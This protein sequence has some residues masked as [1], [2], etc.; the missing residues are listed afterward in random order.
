MDR[1]WETIEDMFQAEAIEGGLEAEGEQ[2]GLPASLPDFLPEQSPR[3]EEALTLLADPTSS[4]IPEDGESIPIVAEGEEEDQLSVNL[5]DLPEELFVGAPVDVE[6]VEVD[7][8][9]FFSMSGS[10]ANDEFGIIAVDSSLDP[11]GSDL[12]APSSGGGY[13]APSYEAYPLEDDSE[14][15]E[16]APSTYDPFGFDGGSVSVDYFGFE[17]SPATTSEGGMDSEGWDNIN[18]S[19]GAYEPWDAQNPENPSETMQE[20]VPSTYDPFG[21]DGG[22]VSVDYFGF[23]A[24]PGED[25]FPNDHQD[26]EDPSAGVSYAPW[27]NQVSEDPSKDPFGGESTMWDN[28]GDDF[29]WNS[30]GGEGQD[31][32]SSLGH[33]DEFAVPQ[34]ESFDNSSPFPASQEP[35][36]IDR[37]PVEE[38]TELPSDLFGSGP[39]EFDGFSSYQEEAPVSLPS[40]GGFDDFGFSQES[41]AADFDLGLGG[42]GNVGFHFEPQPSIVPSQ[43]LATQ[44]VV[45]PIS[46]FAYNPVLSV[47]S[48]NLR[49]SPAPLPVSVGAQP[50]QARAPAPTAVALPQAVTLQRSAV[51]VGG[52]SV[53]QPAFVPLPVNP[54]PSFQPISPPSWGD[55]QGFSSVP[56]VSQPKGVP[57][58]QLH[59]DV[60]SYSQ[61]ECIELPRAPHCTFAFGFGGTF[62]TCGGKE[63]SS[64]LKI[65]RTKDLLS[66]SPFYKAMESFPG[67]LTA[68]SGP[69]KI[70]PFIQTKILE[71]EKASLGSRD[72]I[73]LW[74]LF[75]LL[76]DS[77][78]NDPLRTEALREQVKQL[79]GEEAQADDSFTFG[80][81]SGGPVLQESLTLP[82]SGTS[83]EI[84]LQAIQKLLQQGKREEAFVQAIQ[85]RLYEHALIIGQALGSQFYSQALAKFVQETLTLTCPLRTVYLLSCEGGVQLEGDLTKEWRKHV[86][87]LLTNHNESTTKNTIGKL[88]DKLWQGQGSTAAAHFCYLLAGSQ[89]GDESLEA[90]RLVL[91]GADNKRKSSNYVSLSALQLSELWEYASGPAK[92]FC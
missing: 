45:P 58:F 48:P 56:L 3:Q 76:V 43:P 84:A 64:S 54:V 41:C 68:S 49:R 65:H 53:F 40:R 90:T 11:F 71:L 22:S 14:R 70:L 18:A 42:D 91:I 87:L 73:L 69:R 86:E 78:S 92:Y 1:E 17:P 51:N 25:G 24:S 88:G 30:V 6:M 89:L 39:S 75:A 82:L 47:S 72:H 23:E 32:F 66:A 15:Q 5:S 26:I 83:K 81:S 62:V 59:H 4:V 67:P 37:A 34:T 31:D 35:A 28:Q 44:R 8:F 55:D 60:D 33:P 2:G 12:F 79:L 36:F 52:I 19:A 9:D 27:D 61:G 38:V 63:G 46:P 16:E 57:P 85:S 29:G 21:F 20:E 74:K 80:Q 50:W 10:H 77:N 13:E 7:D